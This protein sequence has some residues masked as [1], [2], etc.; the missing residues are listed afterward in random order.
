MMAISMMKTRVCNN[1]WN[2][3]S[4]GVVSAVVMQLT[5]LP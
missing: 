5:T 2:H 1:G 4:C 3:V